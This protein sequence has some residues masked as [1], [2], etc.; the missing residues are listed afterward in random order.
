LGKDIKTD[1]AWNTISYALDE[2]FACEKKP[3]PD[4]DE[5]KMREIAEKVI[6]DIKR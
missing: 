2:H 6:S 1:A 5:V 3:G 4:F